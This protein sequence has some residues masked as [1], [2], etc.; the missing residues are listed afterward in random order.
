MKRN[1]YSIRSTATIREAAAIVAEKHIGTLPVV[2]SEGRLVGEVGLRDLLSLEMPDFFHLVE[3]F[4]FVHNFGA[5]ETTRPDIEAISQPVTTIM[6][7]AISVEENC[8][9]LRAYALMLKRNLHDLPIVST[10]GILVG[11][12]SRVDIGV[13]ILAGWNEIT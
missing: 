12:A 2:D 9:M 5:V 8:G 13:A 4:D 10:S 11:I 6:E 1:V 7:P 3:D